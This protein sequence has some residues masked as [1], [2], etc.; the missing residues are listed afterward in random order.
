MID[1]LEIK[2]TTCLNCN[3]QENELFRTLNYAQINHLN[4]TKT[5]VVLK[6]KN[7]I[8]NEGSAVTSAY[9]IRTGKIKLYSTGIDGKKQIIQILKKG[10]IIGLTDLLKQNNHELT[11]E[12]LE[13]SIICRIDKTSFLKLL[14]SM[15]VLKDNVASL[16][17]NEISILTKEITNIT[18]R[19]VRQRLAYIILILNDLYENKITMSRQDIADYVGA[20]T[21]NIIRE[22][23]SFKKEN[24]IQ[25]ERNII[26][27]K[28]QNK[29]KIIASY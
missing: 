11:A 5:C 8:F 9:C 24:L 2:N 25:I 29:L 13:D 1:H 16:L 4:N 7:I 14:N 10:N 28:S 19:S 20:S 15:P 23:S 3:I 17:S 6:N 18:Q 26:L 21:E 22:L 12:T 27:V